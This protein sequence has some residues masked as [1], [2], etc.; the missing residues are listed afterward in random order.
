M[1]IAIGELVDDAIVDVENVF[2]RLKENR[3]SSQPRPMLKVIYEASSEVR[4]SIVYATLIVVLVFIPLFYMQGIEGR[5]FR[6]AGHC[7]Y[8]FDYC[9]V[10]GVAYGYSGFV[11]LPA[12]K[13]KAASGK[14]QP[15]GALAEKQDMRLLNYSLERPRPVMG[16]AVL[17]IVVAGASIPFSRY[18]ISSPV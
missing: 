9:L 2:R 12:E 17:L 16:I 7:V 8:H 14:R 5:I 3:T 6:P 10:S 18:G 11:Q 13:C 1:A 4:N 15:Y